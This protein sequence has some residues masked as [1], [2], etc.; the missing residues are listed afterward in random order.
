MMS[1]VH[2]G[3][4]KHLTLELYRIRNIMGG[5]ETIPMNKQALSSEP[6]QNIFLHAVVDL[7]R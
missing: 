5:G 4:R 6:G 1:G 3:T 7:G 2:G